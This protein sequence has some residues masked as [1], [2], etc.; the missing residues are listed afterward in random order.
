MNANN[1][2]SVIRITKEEATSSH[3]DD[4]LKRQMSLRG[5]PGVTRDRGRRWYYQSWLIL[6][7]V[8]TLVA[9][10][11]WA[12]VE[13][14]QND[15]GSPPCPQAG[16]GPAFLRGSGGADRIVHRRG[17]RPDLS[18]AAAGAVVGGDRAASGFCR[19]TH[20]WHRGQSGLRATQRPGL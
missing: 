17:G 20:F 5:D 7:I 18:F 10:L 1:S 13:P 11:A 12:I 15:F 3:V 6:G 4:L 8:G 14:R 19:R 2:D 9:L 16:G